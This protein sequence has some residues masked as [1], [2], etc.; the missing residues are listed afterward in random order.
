VMLLEDIPE[1]KVQEA[2][3]QAETFVKRQAAR[4]GK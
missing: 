2:I 3:Q 1:D 4:K